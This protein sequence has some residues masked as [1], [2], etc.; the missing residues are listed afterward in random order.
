M[1][2]ILLKV[3]TLLFIGV[4]V[5][6]MKAQ[7]IT[8]MLEMA[9]D[10]ME[11]KDYFGALASHKRAM[12]IDS[13]DLEILYRYAQNLSAVNNHSGA[14]RYYYKAYLMGAANKYPL[15]TYHL[16][17][18]YRSSGEYR[19][20]RRYY[21]RALQSYRKQRD[22]Y[23]YQRINQSKASAKWA[24]RNNQ[25]AIGTENLGTNINGSSAEY[26]GQLVDGMLYY[27]AL[28]ADSVK[29]NS[30]IED[31]DYMSK[32]YFYDQAKEDEAKLLMLDEQSEKMLKGQ[33]LA[34]PFIFKETLFFSACD[35]NLNCVIL[36]GQITDKEISNIHKLN[37]NINY[38][39]SNNTQAALAEIEGVTHLFF[40][41]N[42]SGG[43]GGMDIW[44]AK[45]ASF[46]FDEALNLGPVI[47][48]ADDE[49][50]PYFSETSQRLY[51]S[52]NWHTGFGGFD[53]FESQ[54][55]SHAYE[56]PTNMGYG[57]NTPSDD[58][59]FSLSEGLAFLTS[60]RKKD[61]VEK[62]SNC[63]NDIFTLPFEE[64]VLKDSLLGEEKEVNVVVLNKYLPLQLYF[65][66]D[67]PNPNSRDSL[68]KVN[69][70]KLADSYVSR[71]SEYIEQYRNLFIPKKQSL[72]VEELNTFFEEN[73]REGLSE[74][75]EFTPLLLKELEKG[76][77]IEIAVKGFASALSASDYNLT[78]TKRRIKSIENYFS[79]V[80]EGA[81]QPYLG[82]NA[83]N[84]GALSI[85][86]VPYGD[87]AV[88]EAI[89]ESNKVAAIY[90]P[91][92]ARQ[93][94]I[95]LIAVTNS[96]ESSQINLE[97]LGQVSF[98]RTVYEIGEI[99]QG[100]LIERF[101]EL[102]NTG[103]G[104]LTIYNISSNC[105]CAAMEYETNIG[106][107]QKQKLWTTI[108]TQSL[109]GPQSIRF[110]VVTDSQK[111]LHELEVRFNV[112]ETQE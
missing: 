10:Q 6:S 103:E 59:Y 89:D 52:S 77:N 55:S 102:S 8:P 101:F 78:L 24:D 90:S 48:S 42:R 53:V 73:V 12:Q 84:G 47:N 38:P 44:V 81:F 112:I 13:S 96:Y 22:G 7:N 85:K 31:R 70:R 16:A 21:G 61:N 111:N 27:S 106:A 2:K 50:T 3:F 58:Y 66:N 97:K 19:K 30:Q 28:I 94:R 64:I 36:K 60:N 79:E 35:T 14:S 107:G 23:W 37:K 71:E 57:I 108:E 29:E 33:H 49:I 86:A 67:E 83:A 45:E 65:H 43:L 105:D 25:K 68:T 4:T 72:A 110:T 32:I 93:R 109:N 82:D 92:A 1:S 39:G 62:G 11:A 46:G 74:L 91:S 20:A 80:L 75:D 76:S 26:A 87:L 100:E 9:K 40:S 18:S 5:P 63:C 15:L 95:E 17:E 56:K 104:A 41:S 69:Y 51:F 54:L 98:A 88:Q 99:T 34:N